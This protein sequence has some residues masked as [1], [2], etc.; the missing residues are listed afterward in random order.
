MSE[1]CPSCGLPNTKHPDKPLCFYCYFRGSVGTMKMVILGILDDGKRKDAKEIAEE[2]NERPYMA[3]KV[4]IASV[5]RLLCDY[6]DQGLLIASKHRPT[7]KVG[8]PKKYRRLTIKG[9]KR[10]AI[11][12]KRWKMGL[13]VFLKRKTKHFTMT[14]DFKERA[15]AIRGKLSKFK[16]DDMELCKY[17]M[18]LHNNIENGDAN[19]FQ[20]IE[21]VSAE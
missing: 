2:L 9:K 14:T 12:L 5:E 20:K 7:H 6:T 21:Q 4:K 18:P 8:R 3:K 1:I 10:L 16:E 13:P 15:S 17:I 19:N 11:Y